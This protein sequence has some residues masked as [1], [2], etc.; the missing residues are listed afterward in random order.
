M[1]EQ[2]LVQDKFPEDQETINIKDQI[3]FLKKVNTVIRIRKMRF[4]LHPASF[5]SHNVNF[6]GNY[7]SFYVSDQKMTNGKL[8][9]AFVFNNFS[10]FGLP[11]LE[12]IDGFYLKK[13]LENKVCISC[14]DTISEEE[15][16]KHSRVKDR[17]KES[18]I[19]ICHKCRRK[20]VKHDGRLYEKVVEK[21]IKD[22]LKANSG[23]SNG[24]LPTS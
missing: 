7:I 21:M 20:V 24:E 5:G 9:K 15:T 10:Q 6:V 22:T 8:T 1:E 2:F 17:F 18:N 11:K 3:E 14:H 23:G 12:D 4:S 16:F 19:D 13:Y